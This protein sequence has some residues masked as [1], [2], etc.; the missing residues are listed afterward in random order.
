MINRLKFKMKF[1]SQIWTSVTRTQLTK[2]DASFM[3]IKSQLKCAIVRETQNQH[4]QW[5]NL[6]FMPKFNS[7]ISD[8]R[9]SFFQEIKSVLD[10]V[11]KL[12][13]SKESD[14]NQILIAHYYHPLWRKDIKHQLVQDF[15]VTIWKLQTLLLAKILLFTALV[16]MIESK[17]Q[18]KVQ[19]M[20]SNLIKDAVTSSQKMKTGTNYKTCF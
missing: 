6:E 20:F 3:D 2:R 11:P 9:W 8:K 10:L 12:P 4:I 15:H 5:L 1:Q 13:H 14:Y 18:F 19:E 16:Q 17:W 7:I